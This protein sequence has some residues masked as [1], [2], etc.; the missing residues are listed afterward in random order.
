MAQSC[1]R[2]APKSLAVPRHFIGS[3]TE[4][5]PVI[6]VSATLFLLACGCKTATIPEPNPVGREDASKA[7]TPPVIAKPLKTNPVGKEIKVLPNHKDKSTEASGGIV[8]IGTGDSAKIIEETIRREVGIPT[9][10]LTA[11]I[12]WKVQKLY[13]IEE[14]ITDLGSLSALQNLKVLNLRDNAID[15]LSPLSKLVGLEKLGLDGNRIKDLSPLSGISGLQVL[16]IARNPELNIT[17]V[18]KLQKTLPKCSIHHD[19]DE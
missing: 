2:R 1:S 6:R 9:G 16:E 5:F 15:N 4:V 14:G 13:L 3:L 18:Q 10:Q 7:K 12:L 17:E 8:A 19:L 11:G